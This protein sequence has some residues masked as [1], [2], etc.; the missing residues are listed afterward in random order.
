[1]DQLPANQTNSEMYGS[2][3]VFTVLLTSLGIAESEQ[4]QLSRDGFDNIKELTEFF[5]FS[6]PNEIENYFKDIN[7]LLKIHQGQQAESTSHQRIF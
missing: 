6:T 2:N 3:E 5:Q 4:K 7:P 1:M